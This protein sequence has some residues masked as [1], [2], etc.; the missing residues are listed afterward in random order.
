MTMSDAANLQIVDLEAFGFQ[1]LDQ[2]AKSVFACMKD[3][4]FVT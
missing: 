3:G 1:F 4:G 2:P